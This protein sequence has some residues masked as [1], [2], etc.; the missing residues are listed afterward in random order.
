V[1]VGGRDSDRHI[2]A[3]RC[4]FPCSIKGTDDKEFPESGP[5]C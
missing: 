2:A 3:R 1:R 4:G 5:W